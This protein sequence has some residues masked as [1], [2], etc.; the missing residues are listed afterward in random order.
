[1]ATKY[2]TDRC[3]ATLSAGISSL[4]V[5]LLVPPNKRN[6]LFHFLWLSDT[7]THSLSL[8]LTLSLDRLCAKMRTQRPLIWPRGPRRSACGFPRGDRPESRP[9]R[10][11]RGPYSNVTTCGGGRA[12]SHWRGDSWRAGCLHYRLVK[13][14]KSEGAE[15]SFSHRGGL[16]I[17][18]SL[19]LSLSPSLPLAAHN[20]ALPHRSHQV[21][22]RYS[23]FHCANAYMRS[24][25]WEP[26]AWSAETLPSV[27]L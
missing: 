1:M 16:E 10:R 3:Q 9:L 19:S 7:H 23:F 2:P 12:P 24:R 15:S 20:L 21:D 13:S 5:L 14:S 18:C 22:I 17:E 8:S 27:K 4:S 25:L 11:L 6:R 26:E